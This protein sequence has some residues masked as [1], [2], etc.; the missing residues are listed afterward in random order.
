MAK[1]RIRNPFKNRTP[2][3]RFRARL[4]ILI[5]LLSFAFSVSATRLFLEITGYPQLGGGELHIAHVLWGGLFLFTAAL[6]PILYANEWVHSLSALIAG[7][8]VGLFIDEVGKFITSTN[9]YFYPTAAPIIY[10]FFLLT[11]LLGSQV[12]LQRPKTAR[13]K[14]YEILERFT[15][16]LDRDLSTT[17]REELIHSLDEIG[18]SK[19]DRDLS[20][21]AEGLKTYL[22]HEQKNTVTEVPNFLDR[23]R[24]GLLGFEERVLSRKQMRFWMSFGFFAWGLWAMVSPFLYFNLTRDPSQL[25]V[26]IDQLMTNNLVRNASGLNWFEARV[27]MEGTL[28][29]FALISAGLIVFK[30]ER[31]GVWVGLTSLLV[32]LTVVNLL[33][34]YFDQFSTIV[35]ASFQFVLMILCLRYRQRF[36]PK[37]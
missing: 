16:V 23:I 21:L 15:E 35:L 25:Q 22:I 27:L 18:D 14:M 28:G 6:L 37:P 9:D 17:E 3:L 24:G 4:N 29:I 19:K 13:A 26:F 30:S 12:R 2:V 36:L 31:V 34:F 8:G 20:T 5:T 11:A 10:V 1:I 32:N 7:L 33:V